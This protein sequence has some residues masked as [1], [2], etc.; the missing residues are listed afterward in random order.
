MSIIATALKHLI[1]AGVSGD[2]LVRAVAEMEAAAPAPVDQAAEKRRAYDRE[3]KRAAKAKR[4]TGI[5][6]ETVESAENAEPTPSL[7][8]SP[9]DP[10]K[11]IPTPHTHGGS[12]PAREA[13]PKLWACPEGVELPH[14]R[15][16]LGNRRRKKLG[17][18]ETAYLGQLKLIGNFASDEWPPG[19]LVQHAAEKG[20][21]TIVDPSEYETPRNGQR[22]QHHPSGRSGHRRA[23]EID[24]AARQ[25]GFT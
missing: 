25:L 24:D 19:R 15:D 20:W 18:S 12:A 1:A 14:W 9:P 5:P 6:P 21:G 2:D 7:D 17:T 3:R 10:Q 23:D 4:S 22:T 8:K 13:A 11:L 16:F